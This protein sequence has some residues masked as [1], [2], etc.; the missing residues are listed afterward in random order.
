MRWN[1]FA[2]E[3]EDILSRRGCRLGQLDDRAGIHPQKVSRLQHSLRQPKCFPVLNPREL[4][5]TV[6]AFSL[7]EDEQHTLRAAVLTTAIEEMLMDRINQDDAFLAAE[8]IFPI[9]VQI[10]NKHKSDDY[11]LAKVRGGS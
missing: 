2:R 8:Q 10:I 11:G 5:A 4:E 6:L 9:I 3:L 1:I 7:D